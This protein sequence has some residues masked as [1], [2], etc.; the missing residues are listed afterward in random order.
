MIAPTSI[1]TFFYANLILA[2]LAAALVSCQSTAGRIQEGENPGVATGPEAEPGPGPE[3]PDAEPTPP[4]VGGNV[5]VDERPD[6]KGRPVRTYFYGAELIREKVEIDGVPVTRVSI[7]GGAT[8]QHQGVYIM[9]PRIELVAGQKG[10]CVGGVTVRDPQNGVTIRALSADYDRS[11]QRV[12]RGGLPYL[13]ARRGNAT[14]T[15]VTTTAMVR[16]LAKNESILEG[17]VRIIHGEFTVLGDR[18]RLIDSENRLVLE[19]NPMILGRDQFFAGKHLIYY[20]NQKEIHL[21][22]DIIQLGRQVE[23]VVVESAPEPVA[24]RIVSLEVFARGGGRIPAPETAPRTERRVIDSVLSARRI[25]YRFPDG[26]ERVTEV[27]GDVLL[28]RGDLLIQTPSLLADGNDFARIH[29][30]KGVF[31]HDRKENIQVRAGTME[32]ARREETLRLEGDPQIDFFKKDSAEKTATLFGA[33]IERD[34]KSGRTQARGDVRIVRDTYTASGELATYHEDEDVVILEG[35]P[36]L[37]DRGG[38]ISCEKVLLYPK[39]NRVLLLN[40]ITGFR[41]D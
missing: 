14:P 30:E 33:V 24:P 22:G 18:G 28:T 21:D 13:V 25:I 39:K 38:E 17:D 2:L 16:D 5:I 36:R 19:D 27:E 3:A 35:D 41:L 10:R 11:A 20:L 32:Y 9:A 7:V 15:L 4:P 34:F 40:R 26:G 12:D 1:K 8:I 29:T 37:K 31:M 23:N 6:R